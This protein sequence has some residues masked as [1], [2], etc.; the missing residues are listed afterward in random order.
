MELKKNQRSRQTKT[1]QIE[2][3]CRFQEN[4]PTLVAEAIN[5][6]NWQSSSVFPHEREAARKNTGSWRMISL[7]RISIKAHRV[8]KC[9]CAGNWIF[10]LKV[11]QS[12]PR[13]S[14]R[15]NKHRNKVRCILMSFYKCGSLCW[16]G[17]RDLPPEAD[18]CEVSP[19]VAGSPPCGAPE[20]HPVGSIEK[21]EKKK[22]S[23]ES[24]MTRLKV[25]V[26]CFLSAVTL[27]CR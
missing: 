1:K 13:W 19:P 4:I 3:W 21:K 25:T 6:F 24:C 15:D 8:F 12:L 9:L 5:M 27:I 11:N 18:K 26:T 23:S 16:G 20:S 17:G 10:E 2:W 22:K 14:Q 7:I